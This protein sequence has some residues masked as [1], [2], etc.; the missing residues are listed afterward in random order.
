MTDFLVFP[1]SMFWGGASF[2]SEVFWLEGTRLKKGIYLG[3]EMIEE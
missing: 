3:L 1:Q 2:C